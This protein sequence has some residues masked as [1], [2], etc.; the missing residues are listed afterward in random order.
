MSCD[1]EKVI[2]ELKRTDTPILGSYQIYQN[3]MRQHEGLDGKTPAEICGIK[4]EGENKRITSIQSAMK[5]N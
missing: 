2:R 5:D 3:Y 1:R 4:I